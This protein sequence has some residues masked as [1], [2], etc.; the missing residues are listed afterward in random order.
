MT[1]PGTSS[2]SRGTSDDPISTTGFLVRSRFLVSVPID[3]REAVVFHSLFG[4]SLILNREAQS[5]LDLFRTPATAAGAL[6]PSARR[7]LAGTLETFVEKRFLV[8]PDADERADFVRAVRPIPPQSGAH[9]SGLV[10]LAAEQCNLGCPYCIKDRLMDLRPGRPQTRMAMATARTAIDRFFALAVG[11]GREDVCLQFRGG[12]AL[13]NAPVVLEAARYARSLWTRGALDISMVTNATLVTEAVAREMA[14]LRISAEVSIDGTRAIHDSVRF[15]KRGRPTFDAVLSGLER[16]LDAGV[17]VTNVNATMT[18]ES[19]P[20]IGLAFLRLLSGLGVRLVN[21]EPDVLRPV[22]PDPRFVA[23]RLL[24]LRKKGR[25]LGIEVSGCWARPLSAIGEVR[26]GEGI[27]PADYSLL[28]VDALGQ[29]VRWEYNPERAL[30]SVAELPAVVSSPAFA[31]HVASRTPGQIP[32]CEGCEIEGVCQGNAAF[33]LLYEKA[34]GR[35]GLFEHRCEILRAM[36]RSV[37]V[38]KEETPQVRPVRRRR[39]FEPAGFGSP[40]SEE[41]PVRADGT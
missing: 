30:G 41:C 36:T 10:L 22:H 40:L 14:V 21:L 15:T 1:E 8:R 25:A 19:F 6:T 12:E 9:L 37:L 18:A 34:T 26:R 27:P 11:N 28:I 4:T 3:R 7:S 29:V 23:R 2:A 38:E 39:R 35:P 31:R 16:L 24:V 5:L 20:R 17:R 32:E 13:V 33:A